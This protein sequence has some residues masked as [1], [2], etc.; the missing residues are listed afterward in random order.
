MAWRGPLGAGGPVSSSS[1]SWI[2]PMAWTGGDF[3]S[4]AGLGLGW[5]ALRRGR[6]PAG[7]VLRAPPCG[8][9][10]S[11]G[12]LWSAMAGRRQWSGCEGIFRARV[13]VRGVATSRGTPRG[14][15]AGRVE[16]TERRVAMRTGENGRCDEH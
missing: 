15:R 6:T 13:G 1:P 3:G 2:T 10:E 5:L 14:V 12:R 7:V 9:G 11:A 8:V 16:R 4:G